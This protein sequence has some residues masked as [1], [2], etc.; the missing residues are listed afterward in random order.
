MGACNVTFDGEALVYHCNN[1][2]LYKKQ[3]EG[4][5]HYLP[6]DNNL[7]AKLVMPDEVKSVV[8]ETNVLDEAVASVVMFERFGF[9]KLD[10]KDNLT[11]YF[12]H[13]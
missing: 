11:F 1:L 10:S 13:K 7:K 5:L 4:A 6:V 3:G 9:A 12:S 8:V 2:D